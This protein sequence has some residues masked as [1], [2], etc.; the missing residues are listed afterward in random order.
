MSWGATAYYPSKV[1]PEYGDLAKQGDQ[2]AQCLKAC[3]KYGVECHV[4]KVCW[5]TGHRVSKEV[6]EKLRVEQRLQVSDSGDDGQVWLCPSHPVNQQLE[7][8]AML[9]VVRNYDVDGVHF[10]YIRYPGS[11]YCFCEGCRTRFAEYAG[12]A[13]KKWPEDVRKGGCDYE[14]WLEFR[15]GNI[16]KVV[17]EVAVQSRKIRGG[18]KISAAVFRNAASDRDTIGQDWQRWCEEGWLDFVCPMDYIDST[19]AFSNVINAQKQ[20]AGKIPLYPGIGLS[21]WKDGSNYAVKLCEQI[22]T[23]R[24]AG[25]K[26][27]TVFNYDSN[28]EQ[29]LPYLKLG[30]TSEE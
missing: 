6:A 30:V 28:A 16:S 22:E 19:I 15:R 12:H 17:R 4:W 1:L 20:S 7:I 21:C 18:V 14:K 3:R 13:V 2:I 9:E 29:V 5:N 10:D 11:H 23:V 25:L 24:H 27:F 8:D 26:G